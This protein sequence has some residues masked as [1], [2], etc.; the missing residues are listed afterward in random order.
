ML[1][2]NFNEILNDF[3]EKRTLSK[4][5]NEK[6][7]AEVKSYMQCLVGK[8]FSLDCIFEDDA[9]DNFHHDR[10]DADKFVLIA[11]DGQGNVWLLG[12]LDGVVYFLNHDI[13]E[14]PDSLRSMNISFEQ[15]VVM[16]DL[17]G[18]FE[19]EH[20]YPYSEKSIEQLKEQLCY[21]EKSLVEDFPYKLS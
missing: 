19:A 7:P 8:K 14:E 18:Q 16:A 10:D 13:W 6:L 20:P 1:C 3:T 12:L 21:I 11:A 2:R 15:F 5:A 4:Y 9:G 17:L